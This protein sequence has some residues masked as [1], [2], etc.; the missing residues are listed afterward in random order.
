MPDN[1]IDMFKLVQ[2][3]KKQKSMNIDEIFSSLDSIKTEE[4]KQCLD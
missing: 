1:K 4:V 2:E 3:D